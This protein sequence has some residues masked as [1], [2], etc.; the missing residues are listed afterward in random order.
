MSHLSSTL[1]CRLAPGS[2][3]SKEYCMSLPSSFQGINKCLNARLAPLDVVLLLTP[4]VTYT[5][6][7][8]LLPLVRR[9]KSWKRPRRAQGACT[10]ACLCTELVESSLCC[11]NRRTCISG[12]SNFVMA[13]YMEHDKRCPVS[14]IVMSEQDT[15]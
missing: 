14:V 12:T 15:Q 8:T 10:W 4:H 2:L 3:I 13:M 5:T 1:A 6:G 11:Q 7:P 9:R